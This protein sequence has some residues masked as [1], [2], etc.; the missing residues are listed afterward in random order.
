MTSSLSSIRP[1]A[2]GIDIGTRSH[3]VAVPTNRDPKPVQEFGFF[4]E[5]LHRLAQWL[6][7]CN[8]DTV[9]LEATGSF[10]IP[11]YDVL[12][13]QNIEVCLVNARHI[14]N[15]SGRKTDVQ[16]CQWIQQLHSCG[17]LRSSFIPDQITARLRHF[18][19][20]RDSLIRQAATQ[21]QFKR[22][23]AQLGYDLIPK[24][25]ENQHVVTCST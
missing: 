7:A 2:A 20:H 24:N 16:D 10:W 8:I 6:K 5:D 17:L 12:V 11:L 25:Q 9:A 21:L 22:L 19:R 15:V 23:A 1:N 3:F 14:K 18:V 13:E 4:T